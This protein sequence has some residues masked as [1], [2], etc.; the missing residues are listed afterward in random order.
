MSKFIILRII[1]R[2]TLFRKMKLITR[3]KKKTTKALNILVS[4]KLGE[5]GKVEVKNQGKGS[6]FHYKHY[7]TI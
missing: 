6:F 7:R 2:S 4:S 1:S 3:K 5:D